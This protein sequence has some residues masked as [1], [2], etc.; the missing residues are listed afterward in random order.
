M[1]PT[2]AKLEADLAL[3]ESYSDANPLKKTLIETTKEDLFYAK[4]R[5]A[6]Q[7][8]SERAK[9]QIKA[10]AAAF[11]ALPWYK[12]LLKQRFWFGTH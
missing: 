9:A 3:F 7:E 12:R 11:A 5:Q 10:D 2:I 8:A 1:Y 6:K 4:A